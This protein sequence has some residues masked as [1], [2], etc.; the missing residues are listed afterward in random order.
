MKSVLVQ[1]SRDSGQEARFQA[2]LDILR[3]FGGHLTCLQVTPI[4]A[5]AA[6]DPYGVSPLVA[7]TVQFI[8]DS[9]EAEK[10]NFET[11]LTNESLSW[12]WICETG[13]AA[14]LIGDHSWLADLVVVSAPPGER[15]PRLDPP[16]ASDE[17]ILR[18]HAPVL[19]VPEASRGIDCTGPAVIAWNGSPEACAALRAAL[20]MLR[21]AS[22]VHLVNAGFEHGYD[23]PP[24]DAMTYLARHGIA[25]ELVELRAG[26]A[27]ISDSLLDAAQALGASYLVAGAYGHSRL[28][29]H[30]L[31][32]ITRGL[33]LKAKLPLLLGR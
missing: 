12:D 8:R 29:E 16:P 14:R 10:Q 25:N 22:A 24:T 2:A 26:T 33:L 27:P 17:V 32:G 6:L 31:G 13:D 30:L 7:E 11:R 1:I 18:S 3:A 9:E 5:F 23:L 19:I 28:R 15:K 20:P 21:L 4:E